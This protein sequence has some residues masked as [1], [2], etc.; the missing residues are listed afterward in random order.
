VHD[1]LDKI[2]SRITVDKTTYNKGQATYTIDNA[3]IVTAFI[4]AKQKIEI[5]SD[6]QVEVSGGKI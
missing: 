1:A 4:D 6:N 3:T 5:I 2:Q